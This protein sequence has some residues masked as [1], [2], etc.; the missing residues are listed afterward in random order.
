MKEQRGLF[1]CY[2]LEYDV[3]ITTIHI[4]REIIFSKELFLDGIA[5]TFSYIY[6]LRGIFVQS[7]IN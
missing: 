7:V 3:F 5:C 1:D 4:S 2:W 6:I